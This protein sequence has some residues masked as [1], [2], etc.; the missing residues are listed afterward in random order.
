MGFPKRIMSRVNGICPR[1]DK[2]EIASALGQ[3][4][5]NFTCIFKVFQIA[6]VAARL[7]H[8]CEKFE[9]R[10]KLILNCLRAHATTYTKQALNNEIWI[11]GLKF[12]QSRLS[13]KQD[14]THCLLY[15]SPSPRDLSTSRMPSSA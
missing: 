13:V 10:R 6:L 1:Y 11:V 12:E 15:T 5:I 4:R 3:I 9:N 2:Q 7:G 8:F 14:Y